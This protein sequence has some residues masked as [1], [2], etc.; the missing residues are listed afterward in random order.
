M[1]IIFTHVSCERFTS[2]HIHVSLRGAMVSTMELHCFPVLD[3]IL[4]LTKY[5]K[6]KSIPMW[7]NIPVFTVC[8][9]WGCSSMAEYLPDI[10]KALPNTTHQN[11]P[12]VFYQKKKRKKAYRL[13]VRKILNLY[14]DLSRLSYYSF[15]LRQVSLCN[16]GRPWSLSN[17][18]KNT[19]LFIY[20]L[21]GRRM[22]W[23]VCGGQ[24]TTCK[25]WSPPSAMWV[26]GVGHRPLSLAARVFIIEQSCQT[27]VSVLLCTQTGL[28]SQSS[29]CLSH[30][31]EL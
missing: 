4:T 2:I 15:I 5:I 23:H 24:R 7:Q 11:Q 30:T 22:T 27:P 12:K 26:L 16:P 31:L 25:R 3:E 1:I 18:K 13:W 19:R 10:Y 17:F 28:H 9:G 6:M 14:K 29:C 20:S 21:G 8:K